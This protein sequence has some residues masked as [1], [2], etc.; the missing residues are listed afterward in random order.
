[1]AVE[2]LIFELSREGRRG[3]QFP[4]A[5]VPETPIPDEI[6]RSRLDWPEVS[7]IDVVRHF[8]R[9]SQKNHAID[10]NFYPLGS[11]TM[12]YN[13]KINEAVARYSGFASAHPL[14]DEATVQGSLELMFDLQEML[15]N[16]S[17]FPTVTLQ[18]AAGAHGEFTGVLVARGLS[19]LARRYGAQDNNRSGLRAR[20]QPCHC[21][22]GRL[23][24]RSG[25]V[26]CAGATS[27]STSC[28]RR[29]GQIPRR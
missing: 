14:Q 6:R 25:A 28:A 16:I 12:K 29:S 19:P 23:P 2:P 18:P 4:A 8:T 11:C 24:G 5:D 9:V 27:T 3:V 26:G 20:H 21:G 1:M 10:I 13:P 7:E 22:D 15:A 17:G